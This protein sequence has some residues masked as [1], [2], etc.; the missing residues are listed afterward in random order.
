MEFRCTTD[1][2][3][4]L[5]GFNMVMLKGVKDYHPSRYNEEGDRMCLSTFCPPYK[6]RQM[7]NI[8]IAVI[9]VLSYLLTVDS[10]EPCPVKWHDDLRN[11]QE[12]MDKCVLKSRNKHIGWELKS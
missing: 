2:L 9:A 7:T 10:Y 3:L 11:H 1:S 4:T 8:L 5:L 6:A 12:R